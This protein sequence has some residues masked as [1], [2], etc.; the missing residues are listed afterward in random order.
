V[1]ERRSIAALCAKPF[2]WSLPENGEPL[3]CKTE[4][5]RLW[6]RGDCF[7]P[8][9]SVFFSAVSTP[10]REIGCELVGEFSSDRSVK[11]HRTVGG[12][13]R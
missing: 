13:G 12:D 5:P 9:C 3:L 10:V 7:L 6:R 1:Y 11:S 8:C 4:L 2:W